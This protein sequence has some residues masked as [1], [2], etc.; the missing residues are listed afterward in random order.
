M[1]APIP[2]WKWRKSRNHPPTLRWRNIR[3]HQ[4]AILAILRS[5]KG[6]Q[7]TLTP[8]GTSSTPATSSA[9]PIPP[10]GPPLRKFQNHLRIHQGNLNVQ[11]VNHIQHHHLHQF[12]ENNH[13]EPEN[14]V[15]QHRLLLRSVTILEVPTPRNMNH[16]RD[17][18]E[19]LLQ[20]MLKC[21]HEF[22]TTLIKIQIWRSMSKFLHPCLTRCLTR[23]PLVNVDYRPGTALWILWRVDW[24]LALAC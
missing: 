3:H 1:Q 20:M 21:V 23:T 2:R 15:F 8:R 16:C 4:P 14:N 17:D 24:A 5:K 7:I 6:E 22:Y 10:A 13:H 19:K 11:Q 18:G 12:T 9:T